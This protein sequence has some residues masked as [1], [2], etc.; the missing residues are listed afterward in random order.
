MTT[1]DD[2]LALQSGVVAR[3]QLTKRGVAPHDIE[4][5]LRR[6]ELVRVHDGVFLDHTGPPSWLQRAWVGVLIAWPAALARKSALRA[7]DGPGRVGHDDGDLIHIAVGRHRRVALPSGYRLHRVSALHD[8]VVWNASPPRVRV[9][10]ALIDVACTAPDDFAAIAVLAD[11]VQARRT[12]PIRLR[13]CLDARP[14]APRR[15]FLRAVLTDLH[16]GAWS[17]LEQGYLTLVERPHGLPM[18]HRQLR[19]SARGPV[20]RDAAYV[21]YGV[22][23][24]LDGRLWHDTPRQ[25]DLDLDR[26][27]DAAV[28][29]QVTVRVGWGQVHGRPCETADRVARLLNAHGWQ[30]SLRP[31]PACR[32]GLSFAG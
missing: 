7:A 20:Y 5:M 28:C 25:R 30:G 18:A 10:D 32:P 8:R 16:L 23:V 21:D 4:R 11:A 6:R 13:D 17:A 26:D 9:E 12:V 2:L 31:C 22:L 1:Y 15:D 27:L 29:G 14:R 24:E 19:D 3:R